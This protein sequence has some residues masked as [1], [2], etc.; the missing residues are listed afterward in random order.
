[1]DIMGLMAISAGFLCFLLVLNWYFVLRRRV[2]GIG[3]TRAGMVALAFPSAALCGQLLLTATA[4]FYP[5][6][7]RNPGLGD[8]ASTVLALA[9]AVLTLVG[10]YLAITS[11]GIGHVSSIIWSIVAFGFFLIS[12][13]FFVNSFHGL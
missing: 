4:Y 7:E 9:V 2:V 11:K 13:F 6:G 3:P 12:S 10:P 5:L 8:K 1:M